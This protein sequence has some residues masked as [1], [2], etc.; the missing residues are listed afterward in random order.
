MQQKKQTT[1]LPP[2]LRNLIETGETE[3]LD[4]KKQITSLHKIAKTIVSFA[5]H[6]GGIILVG[7]NDDKTLHGINA[8]EETHMLTQAAAFFC[9]PEI[10]IS[11]K[12]YP[13][14]KKTILETVI[15]RGTH[16][17]YF[18]LG[19]DQKWWAHIRVKDQSLLASKVV[20]DVLKREGNNGHTLIEYT[21]KEKALL[22]YLEKN[23][24]IT[25]KEYCKLLNLSRKRATYILVNLISIGVVRVHQTEKVD[26]YTLS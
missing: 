21:S 17:P 19:E 22:T 3:T 18:A 6:K 7:V 23:H 8:D 20:L 24:R 4:F 5:N 9:K 10:A 15:P 26:F 11:I 13:V 14:A 12:Q 2:R 1:N 16:K 25:L